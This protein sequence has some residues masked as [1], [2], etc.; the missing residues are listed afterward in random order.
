MPLAAMFAAVTITAGLVLTGCSGTGAQSSAVAEGAVVGAPEAAGGAVAMPPDA[1]AAQGI[2][3][4]SAGAPAQVVTTDRQ[5]VRTAYVAMQVDDVAK[6]A[7]AVHGLVAK[8]SGVISN[9]QTQA[10]GDYTSSM[11]TAQIPSK[12][13]DAFVADV[14]KMGK[15]DSITV[16]ADDVTTQ[17]VDLDA[18]IKALQTSVDRMTQLLAQAKQIDDLLAIETQL[19]ARQSELDSLTAQRTYLATQ[20]AMSTATITL[21][22]VST[23]EPVDAPGFLTGL[24]N[25]WAAFVSIV[26]IVVTALGFLL[27]FLLIALCVIV[28]VVVLAVRHSRK[29]RVRVPNP[30]VEP[31]PEPAPPAAPAPS[32]D[33]P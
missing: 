24:E 21:S 13:L 20:V 10:S 29:T 33:R 28:P 19:S 27:P 30:S 26:M 6:T 17:V 16:T 8:Q 32:P 14:S 25:G 11:I 18:R 7:F 15:V 5:I 2:T 12:N 1:A 3:T 9:E 31:P 23:V 4:D 22:P